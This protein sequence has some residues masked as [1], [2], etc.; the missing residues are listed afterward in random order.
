MSVASQ[1]RGYLDS[2]EPAGGDVVVDL[3]ARLTPEVA[4]DQ[5]GDRLADNQADGLIGVAADQGPQRPFDPFQGADDRLP[6]G[7]ADGDGIL[8]PLAEDLEV[9]PLDLVELEPLPEALIEVAE[10]IDPSRPQAEGLAEDLGG[11]DD[12]LAGPAVEGGQ[13]GV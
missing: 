5:L 4:G 7:R 2:F 6:L 1:V 8:E 9:A 13:G 12:A 10:V 3:D 11:A